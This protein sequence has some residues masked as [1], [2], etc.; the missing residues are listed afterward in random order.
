M[1]S[2]TIL[3]QSIFR[4][5][6][7][8]SKSISSGVMVCHPLAVGKYSGIVFQNNNRVG[9]FII[10][11]D[12]KEETPQADI[13]MSKFIN[14]KGDNCG[15]EGDGK[16][17]NI[18][19]GGYAVFFSSLG[20]NGFHAE[21]FAGERQKEGKTYTTQ[22][23]EK[24]DLVVSMLLRPGSYEVAGSNKSKMNL[25]VDVPKDYKDYQQ[26]LSTANMVTLS[27]K[28][29]T[30]SSVKA[31]P[32]QGLVVKL[33]TDAN[34]DVKLVKAAT[35]SNEPVFKSHRWTKPVPRVFKKKKKK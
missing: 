6:G 8:S 34:V 17:Y 10:R 15:C 18:R 13:D 24:G 32:G 30:P 12:D 21:L 31:M 22:K 26:Y 29:F 16:E 9:E 28:G 14:Q 3:N 20:E 7:G 27:E 35:V 33:D 1:K 11:C 23:L 4:Q 19:S 25:T 5:Y 2:N